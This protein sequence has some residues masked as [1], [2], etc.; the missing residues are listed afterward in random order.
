MRLQ[1]YL[2][3]TVCLLVLVLM[4]ISENIFF[5]FL[6]SAGRVIII[7]IIIPLIFRGKL[8]GC[9]VQENCVADSFGVGCM[10]KLERLRSL[11]LSLIQYF[12]SLGPN[13]NTNIVT[14][15]LPVLSGNLTRLW[16]NEESPAKSRM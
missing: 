15:Q 12:R 4:V 13:L 7:I 3:S 8:V 10:L 2:T 11:C 16:T 9:E 14:Q 5:A 6:L 1:G